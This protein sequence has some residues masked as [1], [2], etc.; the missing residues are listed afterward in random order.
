MP[1]ENVHKSTKIVDDHKK[2][3]PVYHNSGLKKK[4]VAPLMVW[5]FISLGVVGVGEGMGSGRSH[6]IVL[7]NNNN[8]DRCLR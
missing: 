8:S 7:V 5:N 6:T 4:L 1:T 2:S 3:P